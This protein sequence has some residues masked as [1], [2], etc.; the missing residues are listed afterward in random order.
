MR[1]HCQ[2][3]AYRTQYAH[4]T[5]AIVSDLVLVARHIQSRPRLYSPSSRPPAYSNPAQPQTPAKHIQSLLL[6]RPQVPSFTVGAIHLN[7]AKKVDDIGGRKEEQRRENEKS[8]QDGRR[9]K[10]VSRK[11]MGQLTVWWS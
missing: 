9:S 4:S 10:P 7:P 11:E 5:S 2:E 6:K 1:C 8:N 3:V